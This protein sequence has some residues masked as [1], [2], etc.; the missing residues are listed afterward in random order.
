MK[1]SHAAAICHN[2][3][4]KSNRITPVVIKRSQN[5]V[6]G[7]GTMTVTMNMS[8]RLLLHSLTVVVRACETSLWFCMLASHF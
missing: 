8:E 7:R 6:L 1:F 5:F 4:S 3:L 2:M